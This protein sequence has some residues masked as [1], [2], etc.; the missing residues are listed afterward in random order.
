MPCGSMPRKLLHPRPVD[1]ERLEREDG[2]QDDR[3][4]ARCRPARGCP[5]QATG[6]AST[7]EIV[8]MVGTTRVIRKPLRSSSDA[9]S[10]S[11][12]S[13]PPTKSSMSRS[14]DFAKCGSSPVG[15]TLSTSRSVASGRHV[16]TEVGQQRDRLVVVEVVHD[17]SQDVEVAV[18]G[19]GLEERPADEPA[20]VEHARL[21]E[22][23]L[24]RPDQAR[25][26]QQHAVR[27][28]RRAEH[29]R[30][31]LPVPAADV[32]DRAERREVV[33][34]RHRRPVERG[35]PAHRVVEGRARSR[36]RGRAGPTS[37]RR[38]PP[39][40]AGRPS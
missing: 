14:S 38:A 2:D 22:V 36:R 12:R 19:R 5:C 30:E 9:N 32:D 39:R 16:A 8:E 24:G 17:A 13:R 15:T 11:V 10:A 6:R 31:Q 40:P 35:Q 33:D 23:L 34:R 3:G 28:R 26:L 18:V 1:E 21:A 4:D 27:G 7:S 25:L 37:R 20:T 29:Q